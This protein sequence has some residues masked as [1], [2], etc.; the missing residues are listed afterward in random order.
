MRREC[1][2]RR[3]LQLFAG[4]FERVIVS[5]L[6][7]CDAFCVDVEADHPTLLAKFHSEGK[8][9]VAEADDRDRLS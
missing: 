4:G 6:Q 5:T 8:A 3:G 7:L 1:Q 9:H 2:L